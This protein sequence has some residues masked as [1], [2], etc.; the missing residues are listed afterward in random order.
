MP[1]VVGFI[2]TPFGVLLLFSPQIIIGAILLTS[3][4]IILSTHYRL[5]INY[6]ARQ[7]SEYVWLLGLKTGIERKPFTSPEYLFIKKIQVNQTL[8]SRANST[9]IHKVQYDG[10]LKFSEDDKVHLMTY[11]D[12][13]TLFKRLKQIASQLNLKV[14]DYAQESP[15]KR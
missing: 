5:Q 9:T 14:V 3:G 8:N 13:K 15:A 11:D 6:S 2:L 10:F 4:I 12:K 1:Y 7:Y